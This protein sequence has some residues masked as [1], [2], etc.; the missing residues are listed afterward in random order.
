MH[1]VGWI[2]LNRIKLSGIMWWF[3]EG[4]MN[5]LVL[6]NNEKMYV[7]W[8]LWM[9]TRGIIWST[10]ISDTDVLFFSVLGV[11]TCL[12]WWVTM[13]QKVKP[14]NV[15]IF[16]ILARIESPDG[17]STSAYLASVHIWKEGAKN[18]NRK[19]LVPHRDCS[20]E[21]LVLEVHTCVL[22]YAS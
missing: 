6:E 13:I 18:R 22:L 15:C 12:N 5:T 21:V 4:W 3:C 11:S 7:I 1:E 10:I 16:L 9:S 17:F 2:K 20:Y 14:R 8:I 19:L